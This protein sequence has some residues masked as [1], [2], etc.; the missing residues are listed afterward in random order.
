MFIYIYKTEKK[1]W[2]LFLVSSQAIDTSGKDTPRLIHG[3][4]SVSHRGTYLIVFLKKCME[5]LKEVQCNKT[6][7]KPQLKRSGC[8]WNLSPDPR[9]APGPQLEHHLFPGGC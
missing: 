6:V 8:A 4:T 7:G 2:F 9:V 1:Q 5:Y 3:G